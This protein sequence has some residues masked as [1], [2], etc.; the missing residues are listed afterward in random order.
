ML[1][2]D[3]LP[4]LHSAASELLLP[5]LEGA[6]MGV[7]VV[8]QSGRPV[9]MNESG[10]ALLGAEA[11]TLPEWVGDKLRP[12]IEQIHA[13][14]GPI[15]ERWAPSD[16]VLRVRARPLLEGSPLTVLEIT[17]AQAAS[18]RE[19]AALLSRTLGLSLQEAQLLTLLWRGMSNGEIAAELGLRVGTVKS[20]LFRLYQKLGVKRRAAAVLRAAEV[21]PP[22]AESGGA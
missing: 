12:L 17:V 22:S 5:V 2:T 15:F 20:R 16:A 13:V 1:H 18:A 19:V 8:D 14:G 7:V 11:G 6:E 4:P 10:R 21:I 9:Y 3:R